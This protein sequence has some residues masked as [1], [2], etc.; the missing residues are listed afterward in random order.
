MLRITIST[1]AQAAAQYYTQGLTRANYYAHDHAI[2]GQW[3]GRGA[4]RLGLSGAVEKKHFRALIDNRH[5]FTG[6]QLTPRQSRKSGSK[7]KRRVAYD[8]TFNAPKSLTL[9]Y[10]YTRD[11]RL[12]EAFKSSVRS[13]MEQME[14]DARTQ[15]GAGETKKTPFTGNLIWAEF[16]DFEARPVRREPTPAEA[17]DDEE[18]TDPH[19]HAHC[20][21]SG[22]TWVEDEDRWKALW[23]SRIKASGAF[24]EAA[25]HA[26]L[27]KAVREL[28]YDTMPVQGGR[29][30]EIAGIS[31]RLREKFSLCTREIDEYAN[32]V[33]VIGDKNRDG[34]GALTRSKKSASGVT[35]EDLRAKWRARL[36]AEDIAELEAA[37]RSGGQDRISSGDAIR[38]ALDKALE[39]SSAAER[40]DFLIDALRFGMG[41]VTLEDLE[42]TLIL[43]EAEGQVIAA[44]RN[45]RTWIT[46]PDVAEEEKALCEAV[47]D[48]TGTCE[49]FK[50]GHEFKPIIGENGQS[51]TL[52]E[53]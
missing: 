3:F 34:L 41:Y 42:D 19:L 1:D 22:Q 12:L 29:W 15:S 25:F 50:T 39:R 51:F 47:R 9:L 2:T 38:F 5:P 52:S 11:E 32:E 43:M 30:W 26:R 48:G 13:T 31:R 33:G 14:L 28:G 37:G 44:E 6:E 20:V 36:T 21:V 45:E 17:G 46:T 18:I 7:K 27:S 53:V 35:L 16:I 10:E 40:N 49:P 4:A 8:C 24:Y 23:F